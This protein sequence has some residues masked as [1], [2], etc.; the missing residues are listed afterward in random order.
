MTGAELATYY[1]DLINMFGQVG[2]VWWGA[3]TALCGAIIKVTVEYEVTPQ[4][5]AYSLG[6]A[7]MVCVF[8]ISLI[9][10][11]LFC[12][13]FMLQL[14]QGILSLTPLP[15]VHKGRVAEILDLIPLFY[16]FLTTTFV[17]LGL[18]WLWLIRIKINETR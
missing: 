13:F 8:F 16:L 1:F 6:L 15:L 9:G 2:L 7:A 17:L 5:G 10:Y 14:N 11:G 12:S 4:N 3:A 18:G